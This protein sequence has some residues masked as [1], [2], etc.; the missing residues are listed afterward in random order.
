MSAVRSGAYEERAQASNTTT[1]DPYITMK[2]PS[3]VRDEP[4]EE[5]PWASSS[6][7]SGVTTWEMIIAGKIP[8]AIPLVFNQACTLK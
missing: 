6:R 5:R 1:C 4:R 7:S 3:V 2:S 8:I